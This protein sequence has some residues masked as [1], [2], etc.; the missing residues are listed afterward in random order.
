MAD[1][2]LE[3]KMEEHV[4][5]VHT[6]A[7]RAPTFIP[8]GSVCF[9]LGELRVLVAGFGQ[10]PELAAA[11]VRA[12][13]RAACRVAFIF[14]DR[15]AGASLA[16][17]SGSRH[18]PYGDDAM[19]RVEADLGKVWGGVDLVAKVESNGVELEGRRICRGPGCRQDIFAE[20]AADAC[21]YLTLPQSR[22]LI[23]FDVEI[24]ADGTLTRSCR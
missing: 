17:E 5:G 7:R 21:L 18:Y 6:T 13:R 3:K 2:Y 24:D 12:Y 9:N 23:D 14:G 4:R 1:N 20:K 19:A 15:R 10:Q 8:A 11:I 16:Q 22:A